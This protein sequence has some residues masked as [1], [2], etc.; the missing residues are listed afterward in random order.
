MH[1]APGDEVVSQR[2][3]LP[4]EGEEVIGDKSV[5]SLVIR[6][7]SIWNSTDGGKEQ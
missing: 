5:L 1:A 7:V 6:L 2:P 4:K 3:E